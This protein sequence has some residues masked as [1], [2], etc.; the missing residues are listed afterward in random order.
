MPKLLPIAACAGTLLLGAAGAMAAQDP[1]FATPS[2]VANFGA[3]TRPFGIA[4]GDFDG[5]GNPDLVVGRTTGNIHFVKGNGDG[6]FASPVP[7][8]WK[9][10]FFNAWAFAATDLD[11]DGD[12]DIVWGANAASPSTAPFVVNDGEIRVF[13]GNGDGTFQQSPYSVSGVLHNAGSLIADVGTDAG[14]LAIGDVD[15]D[16]DAD[17][18]AGAVDGANSVVR[19]LRNGG[20]GIFTVDT[21]VSQ[22]IACVIPCAPVY[23]PATSTQNS[24]WGLAFGDA[25]GDG[26][27]DLWIG[28]RALY[29]YLYLNDGAGN[30]TLKGGNAAVAAR[31]NVYLGHDAFRPAVGYTG[32][33]AA[34]DVNGDGKADLMIGLHSGTQTPA[35]A[36]AHDGEILLD[37]SDADGHVGAGALA[38]VGAMARG[39]SI[40]DVDGDGAVD[41]VAGEYDGRI[42]L[43]RQL[44]PLDADADEISDYVDNA[45]ATP[46]APRLDMNTEPR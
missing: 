15:G 45:P 11:G 8:A 43:L 32:S 40:V 1:F 29:V 19:L 2:T 39:V 44:P 46:N 9:Q 3:T 27:L 38:D 14:S 20:G 25:D 5:D 31:P 17:I 26:D 7:F 36:V 41:L 16:G 21:I 33:L 35:A 23:F 10:A 12:L 18:V 13:Y 42:Q 4:A 30:F 37:V 28:D 34:A 6:T 24:P 22:A